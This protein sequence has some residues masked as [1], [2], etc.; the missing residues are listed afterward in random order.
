MRAGRV[1]DGR[2]VD[3]SRRAGLA[4]GPLNVAYGLFRGWA[5]GV[6][7]CSK[8]VLKPTKYRA[9]IGLAQRAEMAVE[10][11]TLVGPG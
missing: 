9:V 1:G 5:A 7:I 4:A 8:P 2:G 3:I 11:G 6:V 10:P